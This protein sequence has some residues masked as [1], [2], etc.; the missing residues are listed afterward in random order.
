[1][2]IADNA[3]KLR[4]IQPRGLVDHT[5]FQNLQNV[6]L[7]M[8]CHIS[9]MQFYTV[10][11]ERSSHHTKE[12]RYQYVQFLA[13][14][15]DALASRY[16]STVQGTDHNEEEL[17]TEAQVQTSILERVGLNSGNVAPTV[18]PLVMLSVPMTEEEVESAFFHLALAFRCNQYTLQKRL[19]AEEHDRIVAQENL[20]LELE[21]SRDTLRTL[22]TICLDSQCTQ[23]LQRLQHHLEVISN[24]VNQIADAAEMLGAVHQEARLCRDVQVMML[25]VDNLKGRHT[26]EST[27]LEATRKLLLKN[28]GQKQ[29]DTADKGE[30]RHVFTRQKSQQHR[31]RRRV[32]FTLI[33]T[34]LGGLQEKLSNS[35]ENT[36]KDSVDSRSEDN[37]EVPCTIA[38]KTDVPELDAVS[39]LQSTKPQTSARGDALRSNF[40]QHREVPTA[41]FREDL[42]TRGEKEDTGI[43][44]APCSL[45]NGLRWR[46]RG[47]E[48]AEWD[49]GHDDR[50]EKESDCEV[51]GYDFNMETCALP[52]KQ[53]RL[54][55]CFFHCHWILY[56][57]FLMAF[58]FLML[59]GILLWP[60]RAPL[61][62]I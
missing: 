6:S 28:R 36:R 7:A 42:Q 58:S 11:F 10:T 34:Q 21:R 37:S 33:P 12:L 56:C 29:S 51:T 31:T 13:P 60:L 61:F 9:M 5:V 46:R 32:S 50:M 53:H 3:I 55:T 45:W 38:G 1:M 4:E 19:Q 40:S 35:C 23:I 25:H 41:D 43:P 8:K 27:E 18:C 16:T 54:T 20:H 57:F 17:D 24:S 22:Q 30:I 49:T 59:L 62:T 15:V 52:S 14:R 39:E 26:E 47:A 48:S 44:S 2:V